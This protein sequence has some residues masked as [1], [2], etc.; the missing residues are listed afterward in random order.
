MAFVFVLFFTLSYFIL[1]SR[2][3][4]DKV[5]NKHDTLTLI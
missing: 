3:L 4:F 5:K 1:F 2:W